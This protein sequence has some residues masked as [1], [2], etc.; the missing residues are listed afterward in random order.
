MSFD[1]RAGEVVGISGVSGNG[2]RELAY[3]LVGL[4]TPRRGR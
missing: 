4:R 3:G 1:V 2:Q